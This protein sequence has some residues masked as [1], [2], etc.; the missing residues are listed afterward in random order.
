MTAVFVQRVAGGREAV[1]VRHGARRSAE[2]AAQGPH[3][4][5]D[6]AL[7]G[8]PREGGR[9]AP[10]TGSAGRARRSCRQLTR[11]YS[12]LYTLRAF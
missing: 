6:G 12:L 3:L 2:G 9:P 4:P 7:S 8:G 11:L 5:G 10:T 1:H